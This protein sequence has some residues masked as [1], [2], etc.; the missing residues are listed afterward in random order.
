MPS[1]VLLTPGDMAY[2][3]YTGSMGLD[4]GVA[5]CVLDPKQHENWQHIMAAILLQNHTFRLLSQCM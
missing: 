1:I 5:V 4:L 2:S 3:Q